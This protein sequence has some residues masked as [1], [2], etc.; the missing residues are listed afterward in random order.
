MSLMSAKVKCAIE[1]HVDVSSDHSGR[2][3]SHIFGF[4]IDIATGVG[5]VE[6][7]SMRAPLWKII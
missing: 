6:F 2:A 1:K 3:A 5:I 4:R 7:A